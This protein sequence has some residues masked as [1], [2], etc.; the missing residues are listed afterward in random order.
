MTIKMKTLLAGALILCA[1]P[2]TSNT[3]VTPSNDKEFCYSAYHLQQKLD[4]TV[5]FGESVNHQK[6]LVDVTIHVR[7]IAVAEKDRLVINN[8]NRTANSIRSFIFLVRPEVNNANSV[9][10]ELSQRYQHPFMALINAQTGELIDLKSTVKDEAVLKEYLSFYDLFQYSVSS[11]EYHY[12]NGNG[13]YQATISLANSSPGKLIRQN[14]GYIKTAGNRENPPQVADS[15]LDI[16]LSQSPTEC[17][18]QQAKGTEHFKKTLSPNAWVEGDATF[19][20]NSDTTATL[21]ADHFFYTL[22]SKLELWPA[23]QKV[24]T[25]SREE[26]LSKLPEVLSN[27][28]DLI[29]DDEEFITTFLLEKESW[30]YLADYIIQ[31]GI[32]DDLSIELF[33]ALDKID[34][35][36][37]VN[38]LAILATSSLQPRD[39]FRAMMALASTTAAFDQSSLDLL[40][41]QLANSTGSGF[42]ETQEL[43]FVRMMGAFSRQRDMTAP[44]QSRQLRNILYSQ[45]DSFDEQ[46]NAAVIDAIG[47]LGSSIDAEGEQI[48]LT[49]LTQGSRKIRNSAAAAFNRVPYEPAF[50]DLFIE[51]INSESNTVIKGTL[52]EVLGKTDNTDTK[53]KQQLLSLLD[54]PGLRNKSLSSLKK[55]NFDLSVDDIHVLESRLRQESDSANQRVLAALILKNRRQ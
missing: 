36:E 45:V 4:L 8:G 30:P 53:V 34:T 11:G 19:S 10:S 31:N 40:K 14:S 27:L 23:F 35:T 26:A 42:S 16:I 55:I 18:Y 9:E 17:F 38:A 22:T 15:T 41:N 46:I 6:T 54:T 20:V 25:I 32:T 52:I 12:S 2:A 49:G 50:S 24:P 28:S 44:L 47:N 33:W 13:R 21:P 1:Q 29:T 3:L 37:S 7:E 51:Q 43:I 5:K 39:Q 48:L